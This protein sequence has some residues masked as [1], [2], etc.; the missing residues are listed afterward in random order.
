MYAHYRPEVG[1][2]ASPA[3]LTP[4]TSEPVPPPHVGLSSQRY[5][6]NIHTTLVCTRFAA[7]SCAR[8]FTTRGYV[9][10]ATRRR[11]ASRVSRGAVHVPAAP[12]AA[13]TRARAHA[14]AHEHAG[15]PRALAAAHR[16]HPP[17]RS[18]S[19]TSSWSSLGSWSSWSLPSSPFHRSAGL[20]VSPA[21]IQIIIIMSLARPLYS[22][23][24]FVFCFSQQKT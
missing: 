16:R 23:L 19:P 9:W 12:A 10:D 22:F 8:L 5:T 14:R 15:P 6:Y 11:Q 24:C 13:E 1:G 3:R 17:R 4:R 21:M 7:A 20:C 18:W 2:R